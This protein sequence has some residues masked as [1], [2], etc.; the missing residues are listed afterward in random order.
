MGEAK[1]RSERLGHVI[2]LDQLLDL[3][4]D[5]ARRVLVQLGLR[6]MTPIFH[7]I[8]PTVSKPIAC[9]WRND[10]EKEV[11]L[12]GVWALSREMGATM[13]SCVSEG[14]MLKIPTSWHVDR[15]LAKGPV[16]ENPNRVEC[17]H[18]M[19]TD[20]VTQKARILQTIRDKPGGKVIDLILESESNTFS[21]RMVDGLI[22]PR[23]EDDAA[24]EPEKLG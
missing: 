14:W 10:A 5:H 1:R 6:E 3:G 20:G 17:V 13:G 15:E 7:L 2:T 19:A 24:P 4:E 21:G 22:V 9:R 11:I 18:V 12:A 8:S 23:P 16:R